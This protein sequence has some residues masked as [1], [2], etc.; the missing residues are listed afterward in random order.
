MWFDRVWRWHTWTKPKPDEVAKHVGRQTEAAG[1]APSPSQLEE[2]PLA[3]NAECGGDRARIETEERS[4]VA[5]RR[6]GHELLTVGGRTQGN[7]LQHHPWHRPQRPD[8]IQDPGV[9]DQ[10]R[11]R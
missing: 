8:R 4:E 6:A 5:G 1:R 9:K 3:E 2:A 7:R 11:S 10:M